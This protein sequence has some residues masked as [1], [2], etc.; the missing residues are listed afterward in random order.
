M[1]IADDI[2]A[3]EAA[4]RTGARSVQYDGQSVTYRS[5]DDMRS[6][7]ASMKREAGTLTGSGVVYPE[8][9]K[10]RE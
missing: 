5:L 3:L 6:T 8:F 2:A 1:A 4:I 7:L 9:V 10:G